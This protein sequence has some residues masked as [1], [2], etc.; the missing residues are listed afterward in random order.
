MLRQ[1]VS[2]LRLPAGT[3]TFWP[4]AVPAREDAGPGG[5]VP[6]R[7]LFWS[8]VQELGAR[9][10]VVLGFRAGVAMGL[11][12]EELRPLHRE[13]RNGV[14][15]CTVWD[16]FRIAERPS[17]LTDIVRYLNETFRRHRLQDRQIRQKPGA[18]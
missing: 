14:V 5:I 7:D 17:R 8:G 12:Q 6:S 15:V 18:F 16:L 13:I 9:V 10:I 2:A 3:S 11:S 1:L 4:C